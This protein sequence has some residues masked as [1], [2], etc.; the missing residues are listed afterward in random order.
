MGYSGQNAC[1]W[2]KGLDSGLQVSDL[3]QRPVSWAG[4]MRTFPKRWGIRK[5]IWFTEEGIMGH[6]ALDLFCKL[7]VFHLSPVLSQTFGNLKIQR[8]TYHS[9]GLYLCVVIIPF[10][11]LGC[12]CMTLGKWFDHPESQLSEVY[13]GGAWLDLVVFKLCLVDF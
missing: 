10:Y 7:S 1:L 8:Q 12:S 13:K 2:F 3:C 6:L 5:W 9:W 11:V 4:A